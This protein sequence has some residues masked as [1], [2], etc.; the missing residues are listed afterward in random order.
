MRLDGGEGTV[1]VPVSNLEESQGWG[2][3]DA[4]STAGVGSVV[5]GKFSG[6]GLSSDSRSRSE[7]N[8]G[9]ASLQER[10]RSKRDLEEQRPRSETNASVDTLAT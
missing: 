8:V 6:G 3:Q 5:T 10:A 4:A 9:P 1:E 7:E 2:G